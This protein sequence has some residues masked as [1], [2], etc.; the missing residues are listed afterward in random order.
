MIILGQDRIKKFLELNPLK[1]YSINEIIFN[2]KKDGENELTLASWVKRGLLK[3]IVW[4][5]IQGK[6]EGWLRF[7]R[8]GKE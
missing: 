8:F 7:Y 1:W 5:E 2:I 4:N 3:L 6:T